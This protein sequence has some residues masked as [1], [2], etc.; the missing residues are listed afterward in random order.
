MPG[1]D[2]NVS[3]AYGINGRSRPRAAF[4]YTYKV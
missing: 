4:A 1:E 3:I 2:K